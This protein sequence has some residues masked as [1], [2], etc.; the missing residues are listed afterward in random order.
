M[1]NKLGR[2]TERQKN[3]YERLTKHK[4]HRSSLLKQASKKANNVGLRNSK[5]SIFIRDM[6]VDKYV[7]NLMQ[8]LDNGDF[9]DLSY[10]YEGKAG[11][12]DLLEEAENVESRIEDKVAAMD[13]QDDNNKDEL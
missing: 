2:N 3:K 1:E 4:E 9:S 10:F 6:R 8:K 7:K 12:E 13:P 5:A 11:D